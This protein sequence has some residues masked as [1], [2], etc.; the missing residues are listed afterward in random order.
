M[1]GVHHVLIHDTHILLED[2]FWVYMKHWKNILLIN[3]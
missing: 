1:V 2:I 3:H